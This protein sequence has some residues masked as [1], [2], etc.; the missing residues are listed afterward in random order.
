M[1]GEGEGTEPGLGGEPVE[2]QFPLHL[3]EA[4]GVYGML[5]AQMPKG[6]YEGILEVTNDLEA[7]F[8]MRHLSG[9]QA[10]NHAAMTS[11]L[12]SDIREWLV[13]QM[14][15]AVVADMEKSIDDAKK[16]HGL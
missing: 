11:A 4:G 13:E 7:R 16:M 6:G 2:H 8:E 3:V 9:R 14:G 15:E 10:E 5:Y 1:N 12:M